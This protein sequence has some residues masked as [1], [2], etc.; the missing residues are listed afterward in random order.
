[1][2]AGWYRC[3]LCGLVHAHQ[4]DR[5]A[6]IL[7]HKRPVLRAKVNVLFASEP[8]CCAAYKRHDFRADFANIHFRPPYDS[9]NINIHSKS[10]LALKVNTPKW[11]NPYEYT[12]K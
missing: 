12:R 2:L 6:N 7:D 10:D 9:L 8:Q 5:A 1:L 4:K 3:A 11:V